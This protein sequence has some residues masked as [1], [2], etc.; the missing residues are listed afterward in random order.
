MKTKLYF[1]LRVLFVLMVSSAKP[2]YVIAAEM[3]EAPLTSSAS[4]E[5][6]PENQ[7][8]Q[9]FDFYSETTSRPGQNTI[10]H[11]SRLRSFF[12]IPG[13]SLEKFSMYLGVGLDREFGAP[14]QQWIQNSWRPQAGIVWQP[15]SF[16]NTWIEYNKRYYS[17]SND[18]DMNQH[19][20]DARAGF[21]MSQNF[22]LH[23]QGSQSAQLENYI[24][25]VSYFRTTRE[26]V[27][28]AHT[29]PVY[30]FHVDDRFSVDPYAELYFQ[31]SPSLDLGINT[32]QARGGLRLKYQGVSYSA[33]L[34]GYW[35][36]EIGQP[37]DFDGQFVGLFVFG[38]YF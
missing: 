34:F 25:G 31:R 8:S 26:P 10:V 17:I 29:R 32:N 11:Q 15:L 37:K 36:K 7:I 20:D 23:E 24:E 21:A 14:E 38:G 27:F 1:L 3:T 22:S 4:L 2:L 16:L 9:H 12:G 33:S 30:Q 5:S 18:Q 6:S 35:P 19:Q 28:S 13:G